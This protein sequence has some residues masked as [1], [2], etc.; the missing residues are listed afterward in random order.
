MFIGDIGELASSKRSDTWSPGQKTMSE[1]IGRSAET[2]S[3][4]FLLPYCF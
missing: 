4:S 1:K 3:E 2:K